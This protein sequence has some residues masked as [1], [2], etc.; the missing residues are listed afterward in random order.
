MSNPNDP[1]GQGQPGWPGQQ[2][3]PQPTRQFPDP[4]AQPG[5]YGGGP[6]QPGGYAQSGDQG[7]PSGHPQPGGYVQPPYGQPP[8]G[9]GSYG[10]APYGQPEHQ[11]PGAY[12]QP[13]TP[14]GGW[15]QPQPGTGYG[16]GAGPTPPGVQYPT[17]YGPPQPPRRRSGLI[18]GS[19]VAVIALVAAGIATYF[20]AFSS[21]AAGAPTPREA[22]LNLVSALSNNDVVGLFDGLA[23]AEAAVAKDYLVESL[24]E[25]KRLGVIKPEAK[26]E[27]ITGVA[28]TAE[29]LVFDDAAEEKVND[30]LSIT[31]LVDGTVTVSS[32]WN[33]IPLTEKFLK[34]AFPDGL[35]RS[36]TRTID[37]SDEIA[38]E[39]DGK[40]I[41]IA[42]VK[43]DGE[44]YPSLFYSIADAALQDEG[45]QWPAQPIGAAGANSPDEAVKQLVNAAVRADVRRLIELTPPDEMAVLHDAGQLLIDAAEGAGAADATISDLQTKVEDVVGGKRVSITKLTVTEDDET[46]TVQM[47]GN[48]VSITESADTEKFCGADLAE[49]LAEFAEFGGDQLTDA[50]LGAIERVAVGYLHTGLVTTEVDGKWYVSPA[51][52][53]GDISTGFLRE[54]RPGD[55]ETLIELFD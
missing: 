15:P 18:A 22:A 3:G 10:Q 21:A 14:A 55:L 1:Y 42:T 40:P 2:P 49:L 8:H 32:D 28:F 51:R 5:A 29:Q 52:S 35:P 53:L 48:C 6:G 39:N 11:Q 33:Q 12:G 47:D 54:L 20:F 27:Q 34:K 23:P 17:A 50:Q 41:R 24:D 38:K 36:E 4:Y 16:Y 25:L 19:L 45:L 13:P 30:H 37:I 43:V 44:W 9:Q 31:K 26:P 7:Q 46:V